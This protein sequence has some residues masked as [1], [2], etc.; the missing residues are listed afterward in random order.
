MHLK[1]KCT[2]FFT[3]YNPVAYQIRVCFPKQLLV[4]TLVTNG[5]SAGVQNGSVAS[6][7]GAQKLLNRNICKILWWS[8]H[9]VSRPRNTL[10][11]IPLLL[12]NASR[13][14]IE[15]SG[16]NCCLHCFHTSAQEGNY[17][18]MQDMTSYAIIFSCNKI[19]VAYPDQTGVCLAN[20]VDKDLKAFL[21]KTSLLSKTQKP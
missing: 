13:P 15:I 17:I 5:R 16:F 19:L 6:R 14:T 12:P 4:L 10:R 18:T 21:S 9:M 7:A 3:K 2:I 11:Q 20:K 1:D 8:L